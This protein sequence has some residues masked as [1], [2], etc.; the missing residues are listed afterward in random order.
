MTSLI[1][2]THTGEKHGLIQTLPNA[3]PFDDFKNAAPEI[4]EKLKKKKKDDEKLVKVRYINHEEQET[5]RFEQPYVTHGQP[6]QIWRLIHGHEYM[7]PMGFVNQ[8]NELRK[9]V[10]TDL[11]EVDGKHINDNGAPLTKE[12]I[13]RVHEVVPAGFN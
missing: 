4:K 3:V 13:K 5:G 1:R 6:I 7:M 12:G 9:P 8:I 11:Q 2:V 10:R